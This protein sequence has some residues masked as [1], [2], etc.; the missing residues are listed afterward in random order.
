MSI[1]TDSK[2]WM[3]ALEQYDFNTW[4]HS[5]RVAVVAVAL[6]RVHAAGQ[7]VEK[8]VWYGALLHDIGKL[9]IPKA[10]L[11]KP[12][13]LTPDEW[14][15]MRC[16][17]IY[18]NEMLTSK[19]FY[20][21]VVEVAFCHHEKWDGSGYPRGLK[22]NQIP[23]LARIFQVVDVWDALGSDRPYR[24]AWGRESITEYI[25]GQAGKH[26]DPDIVESFLDLNPHPLEA[27]EPV[28]SLSTLRPPLR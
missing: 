7:N 24:K 8:F 19:H 11:H 22:G 2:D 15:I 5:R 3:I 27:A 9:Y 16:H 28:S 21:G 17:P 20:R 4:K 23:I 10:I 18:A 1:N 26:F 6:A 12:M 14:E 25:E 13:S